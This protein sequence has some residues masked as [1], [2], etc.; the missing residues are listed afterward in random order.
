[1]ATFVLV[2]GAFV[3]GW[4]WDELAPRL[5][6]AGHTVD[7]VPQLPSSGPDPAALGDLAADAEVVR[8]HVEA[9]G[10]PVVLVGHSYGGMVVTE[11]A[12]HP[13][14]AHTVYVTALWPS[15]G[16]SALDMLAS[17]PPQTWAAPQDDGTIRATDDLRELHRSI[18]ADVPFDRA[19]PFLRRVRP[20]S[21]ASVAAPS[22]APDRT[23]PVTYVLCED[24]ACLPLEAQEAMAAAADHVERLPSSHAPMFSGP[25]ELAELLGRIR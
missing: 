3:G 9:A 8:R 12:D 1:M 7:V 6:K 13:D 21:I 2:H 18:C 25:D 17:M 19:E 14:V 15:R 4:Y 16:A 22:S 5:E 24:D 10:E 11:L 23:H 20:H